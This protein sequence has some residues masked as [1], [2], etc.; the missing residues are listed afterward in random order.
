MERPDIA[1]VEFEVFQSSD[2]GVQSSALTARV[3]W[4]ILPLSALRQGYRQV[5]LC[6]RH[7][8]RFGDFAFA[9]LLLKVDI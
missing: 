9:T 3:G 1:Q 2:V 6:D 5:K 7:G 4:A 8:Q